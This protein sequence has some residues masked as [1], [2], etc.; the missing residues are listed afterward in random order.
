M[1]D[2]EL[3]AMSKDEANQ[4]LVIKTKEGGL[5]YTI[6]GIILVGSLSK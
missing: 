4:F 6:L 3:K 1:T 2:E 5:T